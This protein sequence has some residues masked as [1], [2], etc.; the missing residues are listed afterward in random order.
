MPDSRYFNDWLDKAT[1]RHQP[2]V[3]NMKMILDNLS[4]ALQSE[5]DVAFAYLYGSVA[6]GRSGPLSDVDIAVFFAPSVNS[7]MRF[8]RRLEL[9]S[10]L[11]QV[12]QHNKVE[13][14]P[15]Q[16]APLDLAFE[17]VKNGHLICVDDE[18]ARKAFIFETL[19]RYH[20]AA[21]R[22]K[23]EWEVIRQRIQTRQYGRP[24]RFHSRAAQ[25]AA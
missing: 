6:K 18:A 17:I 13:V 9:M 23:F 22:R 8:T 4:R 15:L 11:G 3:Q 20:D 5:P 10:K 12:L 14:V 7:Q 16:D 2:F 1:A 21:P 19:R 24:S 25:Q